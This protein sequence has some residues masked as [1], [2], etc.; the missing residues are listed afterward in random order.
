MPTLY[1]RTDLSHFSNTRRNIKSRDIMSAS[2]AS[3]WWL[4]FFRIHDESPVCAGLMGLAQMPA[5]NSWVKNCRKYV[6]TWGILTPT[7]AILGP[8]SGTAIGEGPQTMLPTLEIGLLVAALKRWT[9]RVDSASTEHNDA[10]TSL[11]ANPHREASHIFLCPCKS[12]YYKMLSES[13]PNLDKRDHFEVPYATGRMF[14]STNVFA[15]NVLG[16]GN[17]RNLVFYNISA[18]LYSFLSPIKSS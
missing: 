14:F 8:I 5:L 12:C 1:H 18:G 2:F 15:C 16:A 10:K 17:A 7:I 4:Y 3:H 11:G 13:E 9:V 6:F